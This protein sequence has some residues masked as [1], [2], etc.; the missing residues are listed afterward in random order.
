MSREAVRR[1]CRYAAAMALVCAV[2]AEGQGTR[3]DYERAWNLRETADTLYRTAAKRPTWIAGTHMLWYRRHTS[4]GKEFMLVDAEAGKTGQ[5]FD[6]PRLAAALSKASG[7]EVDPYDLPFDRITFSEG[8]KGV[9]FSVKGVTW[10]CDLAAYACSRTSVAEEKE[11]RNAPSEDESE[12][13]DYIESPDGA[14]QAYI[15]GFNVFVRSTDGK[16]THQLSF[17]GNEGY[18]YEAGFLWSPD[19]KKLLTRTNK[20]GFDR[21]VHYIE[22]SPKSQLQPIHYSRTY[23]KPGDVIPVRKP[24]LFSVPEMKQIPLCDSLYDNPYYIRNLA[25][26]KDGRTCT[27]EY[28][29]R[30]HQV[31]RVLEINAQTGRV[32]TLVNET[33]DTFFCYY[34]KLYCYYCKEENE[35]IWMSERDGW[36]HLYLYDGETATVKNQIT[37]GEWV[38]RKVLHVDEQRREIIFTAGGMHTGEDPYHIHCCRINFDG[39]GLTRLT[40]G[41][42]THQVTFSDDCR[43]FVDTASRV[44]Q[45]PVTVLRSGRDGR[46]L[47]VLER[48]DAERL[49]KTGWRM[50]EVFSAKGRDGKTDIWGIIIR[51]T[52]FDST[53]TY[54]VIE[55]IYAGPH[56][57]FVPKS[58]SPWFSMNMLAELGFIVVQIDGMGT[59]NRSKA[60]HDVCYKNLKDAGFPDR[61]AWHRAVAARYPW[62]DISRGVGIYG[63][64]AGGQNSTGALL[65]HPDFYTVAVSS[66]GCHDN[67]M[68]KISW[69]EQ[70]MGYPVGPEYAESSNVTNAWRLQG[71]LFLIV[72]ELDTNVDPASTMQVVDALIKAGKDFDLLVLPGVGHSLGG[73]YGERRRMD[74]FV[75]HLLKVTPP[76]WNRGSSD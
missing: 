42:A 64:S 70:W 57:S 19:S 15:H 60:F 52:H 7:E 25:W 36:N 50:P 10:K 29:Q 40:G 14:W 2:S 63:H 32:R 69:N 73:R 72:G 27:F 3:E 45:P 67:R 38:V 54:P 23:Y 31:Y 33:S 5:A 22:S 1:L 6:Q 34:G 62:Y 74:F 12:N 47:M 55:Y 56:N 76:D 53:R 71:T 46:E 20:P 24:A 26:K 11:S 37:R 28:N 66:C 13:D 17:D 51:P 41:D 49:L 8:M 44:D 9:E 30:G 68:D 21:Q 16:E 39:T 65:F 75:E 18:Y 48:G 4:A 43:Y 58:F 59:S 61:I 35:L